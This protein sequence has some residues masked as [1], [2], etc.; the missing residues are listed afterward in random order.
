MMTWNKIVHATTT[1]TTTAS[2][3]PSARRFRRAAGSWS[4]YLSCGPRMATR[5]LLHRRK[6]RLGSEQPRCA[7][8][9]A[10][11]VTPAAAQ[12]QAG[13]RGPVSHALGNRPDQ[14]L[15]QAVLA[16]VNVA[17]DETVLGLEVGRGKHCLAHDLAAKAPDLL[18]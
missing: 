12:E 14:Q 7:G 18:T 13:D 9:A 2:R 10:A 3:L 16:M 17:A 1:A 11:G 5:L 15:I 8:D 4:M 6:D